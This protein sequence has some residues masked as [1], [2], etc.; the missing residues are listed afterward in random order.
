[1]HIQLQPGETLIKE[2]PANLLR[3]REHVGGR[4]WLTD[5][6]LFFDS[7][8]FNVNK[9]ASEI[10]LTTIVSA[11]PCRTRFLG[12]IPIADKSLKIRTA[13]GDEYD[14]VVPDRADW[15]RKLA[16]LEPS[17]HPEPA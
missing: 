9:G 8:S 4:L 13:N 6:R 2:G 11:E 5:S 15:L 12:L 16:E 1:M 3:K 14:F 17:V 10:L 7:H